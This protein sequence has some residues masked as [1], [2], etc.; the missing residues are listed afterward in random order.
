MLANIFFITSD[1]AFRDEPPIIGIR[2]MS[3]V[4][5]RGV[6]VWHRH[7]SNRTQ[8]AAG[9][10]DKTDNDHGHDDDDGVLLSCAL[11]IDSDYIH[12][13]STQDIAKTSARR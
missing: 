9:D 5:V 3:I 7:F 13:H 6:A 10:D 2:L 4:R 1:H 11:A 12:T 8:R